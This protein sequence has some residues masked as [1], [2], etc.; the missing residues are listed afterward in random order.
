MRMK[1]ADGWVYIKDAD[2]V[3]ASRIR[4]WGMRYLR[5][6]GMFVGRE[7]VELLDRLSSMVPNLPP[8]LKARREKMRE[9]QMAVDEE[10][11]RPIDELKPL[12]RFPVT[13]DL[14][15]HQTRAA[16]MAL[17]VFG[18]IDPKEV[19]ESGRKQDRG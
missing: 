15:A 1:I 7:T 9:T 11:V 19:L 13:K 2:P 3:Q 4:A 12:V 8:M 18:L 14:Y 16:N 10:R 17:I 5:K 6:D